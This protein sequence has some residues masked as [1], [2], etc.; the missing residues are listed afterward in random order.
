MLG[1][2]HMD[3]GWAVERDVAKEARGKSQNTLYVMP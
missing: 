1:G 2:G 3:T